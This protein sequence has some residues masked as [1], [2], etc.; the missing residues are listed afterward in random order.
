MVTGGLYSSAG[1]FENSNVD[2]C[3]AFPTLVSFDDDIGNSWIP[4]E[5]SSSSPTT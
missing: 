4:S 1:D 2:S 3:H 5:G